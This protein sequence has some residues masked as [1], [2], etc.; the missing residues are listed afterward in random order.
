MELGHLTRAPLTA[1]NPALP[2]V[3]AAVYDKLQDKY[4]R[5]LN[6]RRSVRGRPSR[7][8]K[9]NLDTPAAMTAPKL[10]AASPQVSPQTKKSRRCH[11]RET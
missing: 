7:V 2:T 6:Q 3:L 10:P 4:G 9:E 8:D 11:P 1:S 5:Q